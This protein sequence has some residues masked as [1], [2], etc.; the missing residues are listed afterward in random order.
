MKKI[1][2]S[3]VLGMAM[4]VSSFGQG[5]FSFSDS[6]AT[7]VIDG[8]S[9]P[10]TTKKS[11]ANVIVGLLWSADS[12]AAL[13][14]LGIGAS[15]TNGMGTWEG[16]TSD[17]NFHLAMFNGNPLTALTRTGIPLG[18]FSGGVVGIDGTSAGQTVALYIVG[19]AAADGAAGF[20]NS[21]V[22]GWSNRIVETL[23]SS[24]VPGLALSAGMTGPFVVNAVPEPG[25][26]ALAGLGVAAMLASRRRK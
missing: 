26:F 8:F 24:G 6:A 2:T 13:P 23:G 12:A 19:W 14:L 20:G 22:M 4:C 17:A 21:G 1:I 3:T 7:A 9:T 15:G 18:T 10:G 11:A 16:L 5:Y 25:T